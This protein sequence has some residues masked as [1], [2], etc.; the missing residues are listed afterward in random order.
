MIKISKKSQICKDEDK[1]FDRLNQKYN[2]IWQQLTSI[3]VLIIEILI[4]YFLAIL[5]IDTTELSVFIKMVYVTYVVLIILFILAICIGKL[6]FER[7]ETKKW[8]MIFV[9]R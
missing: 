1:F 3:G 4:G 6:E 7:I 8:L 9:E 5:T 2:R